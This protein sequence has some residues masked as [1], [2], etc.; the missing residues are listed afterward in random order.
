MTLNIDAKPAAAHDNIKLAD[1]FLLRKKLNN[2]GRE[3]FK[4]EPV[5]RYWMKVQFN[6]IVAGDRITYTTKPDNERSG[7]FIAF[8][9]PFYDHH[10]GLVCWVQKFSAPPEETVTFQEVRQLCAN[11]GMAPMFV[12]REDGELVSINHAAVAENGAIVLKINQ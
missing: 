1:K 8:C 2:E 12:E 4:F 9:S 7:I 11:V 3:F 10:H 5:R 6:Q